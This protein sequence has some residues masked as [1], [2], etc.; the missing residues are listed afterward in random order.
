MRNVTMRLIVGMLVVGLLAV[1]A[2]ATAQLADPLSLAASGVLIPYFNNGANGDLSVVEIASPVGP[3]NNIPAGTGS[4]H[5]IFY[6]AACTRVISHP[7][8]LTTNDLHLVL[9]SSIAALANKN[10]LIAMANSVNGNDLVPLLNPVHVK[11]YWINGLTGRTRTLE[12]ITVANWNLGAGVG[13]NAVW[14]PLRSGVTYFAPTEAGTIHTELYLICPKNTIQGAVPPPIAAFPP[15]LFPLIV[16]GFPASYPLG[17]IFGRVY[18][19]NEVL[20]ANVTVDCDCLRIR[21]VTDIDGGT[22]TN[23]IPTYTELQTSLP[24]ASAFGFTGYKSI[25][26]TAS[27]IDLFGRLNNAS[28]NELIDPLG[29][30]GFN[31]NR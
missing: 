26:L 9:T 15:A 1:A 6:D 20:K 22:F 3:N 21:K 13:S 18:D 8:P 29:L 4:F 27:S 14:N 7:E 25:F 28:G 5:M 10:G 11:A 12:Q 2:P 16:P 23:F 30:P 31:N 24:A 19:T 17:T